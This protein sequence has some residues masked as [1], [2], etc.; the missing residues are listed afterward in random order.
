MENLNIDGE[1][2]DDYHFGVYLLPDEDETALLRA[3]LED[4]DPK[5]DDPIRFTLTAYDD[6]TNDILSEHE[7][8]LTF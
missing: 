7:V 3:H 6:A 5:I 4:D 2:L 1:E 8:R